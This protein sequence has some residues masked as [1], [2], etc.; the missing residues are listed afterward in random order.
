MKLNLL[1][2]S[3]DNTEEFY[4][5]NKAKFNTISS[6]SYIKYNILYKYFYIYDSPESN[7]SW[8]VII[9]KKL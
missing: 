3:N 2:H 4:Y 7:G 1:Q 6:K 9:L 8:K 5:I